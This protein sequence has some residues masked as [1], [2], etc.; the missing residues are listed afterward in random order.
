MVNWSGIDTVLLDMDGTL[1]DLHFDNYFW[2]E[3]LPGKYASHHRCDLPSASRFL[4]ELSDS[5][6]GTLDWYCLDYW[7]EKLQMDVEALK[8]EVQHLIRF[9]PGT[10][11]FLAFL[12]AQGKQAILVTNAHPKALKLKLRASGLGAHLTHHVSS[13]DLKL[14]KE[15]AGFWTRL[16]EEQQLD[17]ERCL[18]IDDSLNVLR[19]ARAEGVTHTLQVL[20]P[21]M[22]L[23][24]RER[25]EF[26][27]ILH[28][29]ELMRA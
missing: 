6:H 4:T 27:G 11:E 19:R 16:K 1:L 28:F 13:H 5:L 2:L 23:A 26:P 18:F 14:A 17:F 21:D 10:R 12:A 15:N 20:Q 3:F 25:S 7:S 29:D 22:T 8:G 9:R 24:P